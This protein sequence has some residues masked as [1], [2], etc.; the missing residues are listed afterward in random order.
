MCLPAAVAIVTSPAAVADAAGDAEV[1]VVQSCLDTGARN[2]DDERRE[3]KDVI[4]RA[5]LDET[6]ATTVGMVQCA[7][8]ETKA[9]DAILNRDYN[10]LMARLDD[11]QREKLGAAQRAWIA[12][13]DADCAFPYA[14]F[15]G[16]T[17]AHPIGAGCMLDHTAERVIDL[18]GYLDW[19]EN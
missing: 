9:W 15:E 3:C 19:M 4:S 18:R 17:I 8:R 12:F 6:V 16:G 1:A 14:F 13:R 7:D 11:A 2:S 10:T 5:C